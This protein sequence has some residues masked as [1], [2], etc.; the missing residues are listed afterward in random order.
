MW[1]EI[2]Q[3]TFHYFYEFDQASLSDSGYS[4]LVIQQIHHIQCN[5][6]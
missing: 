3:E 6:L 5:C 1:E 2:L 4:V